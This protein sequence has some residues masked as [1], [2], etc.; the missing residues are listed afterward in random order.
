MGGAARWTALALTA[1]AAFAALPEAGLACAHPILRSESPDGRHVLTVC[2][3]WTPFAM[4]GQ[5]GDAP[6]VVVL[7]DA[8]GHVEGAVAIGSLNEIAHAP[9]W[10]SGTAVIPLVAEITLAAEQRA[11]ARLWAEERVWRLRNLAFLLPRSDSFR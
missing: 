7:R 4:P 5:G 3:G 10:Q 11:P 1:A 9:E 8:E 2:R 6:G